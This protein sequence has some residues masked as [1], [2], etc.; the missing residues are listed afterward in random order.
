MSR[1]KRPVNLIN[2]TSIGII[3]LLSDED[4]Y[5]R[6]TNFTK[7]LQEQGKKVHVIGLYHYNRIPVFY[8]PKLSYD[9][10]LPKDLDFFFRPS[11]AF[12]PR[13]IADP[14]DMLIDLSSPDNF[15]LHYI[16]SLSV[17]GF[18]IG[19]K[20]DDRALP[21]DI[22]I[23]TGSNISS[24]ELIEQIVHYTSNLDFKPPENS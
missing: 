13:F 17:A 3:Y 15:T 2:A 20:I 7:R 22:M 16:A 23:D 5:N 8:I 12:V 10:L 4:E 14:F 19:R 18:K 6:V 9:L 11:A 24:Q 1:V 21:Y